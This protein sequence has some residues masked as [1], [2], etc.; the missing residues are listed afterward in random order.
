MSGA[1][2]EGQD[3]LGRHIDISACFEALGELAPPSEI[4]VALADDD[5]V[6][7]AL[8]LDLGTGTDSEGVS[9]ILRDRDLALP[10]DLHGRN[11]PVMLQPRTYRN[12]CS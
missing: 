2:G 8:E 9:E 5:G 12:A 6:L 11:L 1:A 4:S 10:S 3:L 7:A